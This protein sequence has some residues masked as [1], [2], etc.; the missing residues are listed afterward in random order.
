MTDGQYIATKMWRLFFWFAAFVFVLFSVITAINNV[1]QIINEKI[2][3]SENKLLE[4]WHN[5]TKVNINFILLI[6][7]TLLIIGV[8]III[9]IY[10]EEIKLHLSAFIP[11]YIATWLLFV[12][13]LGLNKE[14]LDNFDKN[15]LMTVVVNLGVVGMAVGY[16]VCKYRK[17]DD[18]GHYN[19]KLEVLLNKGEYPVISTI[20]EL[21]IN[22]RDRKE[23]PEYVINKRKADKNL[24]TQSEDGF[25][26]AIWFLDHGWGKNVHAYGHRWLDIKDKNKIYIEWLIKVNNEYKRFFVDLVT[27][28]VV[29]LSDRQLI[30]DYKNGIKQ[31]KEYNEKLI[32]R[33]NARLKT[34]GINYDNIYMMVDQLGD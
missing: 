16:T 23:I 8:S 1:I 6:I 21:G 33:I 12:N 30:E 26:T 13:L 29:R 14:R 4:Q 19:Y 3:L 31:D 34:V 28:K 32:K 15:P 9:S 25:R 2:N 24:A 22:D 18:E 17:M 11:L 10:I 7:L 27:L 20:Y 5:P